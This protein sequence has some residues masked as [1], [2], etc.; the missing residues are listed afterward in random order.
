MGDRGDPGSPGPA[1]PPVGG[2][3]HAYRFCAVQFLHH[4]HI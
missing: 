1:G 2:R 3:G 4:I